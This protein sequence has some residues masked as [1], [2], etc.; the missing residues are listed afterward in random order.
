M[1]ASFFSCV[2]CS[3]VR[4]V[5]CCSVFCALASVNVQKSISIKRLMDEYFGFIGRLL[6]EGGIDSLAL[7]PRRVSTLIHSS[8][9]LGRSESLSSTCAVHQLHLSPARERGHGVND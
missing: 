9:W 6:N 7:T 4:P 1:G 5:S 3:S 8:Y 2:A